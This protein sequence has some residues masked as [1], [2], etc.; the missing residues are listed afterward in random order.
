MTSA[1]SAPGY[2]H[3]ADVMGMAISI[4]VRD[5][6]A[7]TPGLAGVLEWFDHV[8]R[9]FSTYRPDSPIARIGRGEL[10]IA[11]A[12]TEVREVLLACEALRRRT[13]GIFDAFAVPAPNG[14]ALDPSGYVKGWSVDRAVRILTDAGLRDFCINAG[15][16]VRIHGHAAPGTPWTIGIRHPEDPRALV[17]IVRASGSVAVA[18]SATYERGAHIIDPRTGQRTTALASATVIGPDL[19]TTDAYATTAF[20]L[21]TGALDWIACQPIHET[22]LVTH[23][24]RLLASSTGAELPAGSWRIRADAAEERRSEAAAAAP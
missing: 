2:S 1:L 7:G 18:T 5:A 17:A 16:D 11:D 24:G 12:E 20:I 9:T 15:G 6:V 19:G 10:A 14:T 13:S 3:V 23:D 4:D 21:G 8:D 22:I